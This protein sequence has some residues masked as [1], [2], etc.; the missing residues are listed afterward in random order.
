VRSGTLT[1]E[2][3]Q[4]VAKLGKSYPIWLLQKMDPKLIFAEKLLNGGLDAINLSTL[5]EDVKPFMNVL[6]NG[7][8]SVALC[9]QQ[10]FIIYEYY[11]TGILPHFL[12]KQIIL[13]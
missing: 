5:V 11:S 1:E 6:N 4:Y 12:G 7:L 13:F 10:E 9:Y 8:Y 2:K 3:K